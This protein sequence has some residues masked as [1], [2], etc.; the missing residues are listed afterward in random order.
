MRLDD[1]TDGAVD[2]VKDRRGGRGG[3]GLGRHAG[4]LDRSPPSPCCWSSTPAVPRAGAH[5]GRGRRALPLRELHL[6]GQVREVSAAQILPRS[7]DRCWC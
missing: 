4:L 5:A 7:E 6:D 3:A 1:L 2:F